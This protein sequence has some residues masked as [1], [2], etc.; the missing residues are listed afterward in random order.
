MPEA[1]GAK[2]K[3]ASKNIKRRVWQINQRKT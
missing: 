1:T 3:A 2:S